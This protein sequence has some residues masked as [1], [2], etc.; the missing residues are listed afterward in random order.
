MINISWAIAAQASDVCSVGWIESNV[1]KFCASTRSVCSRWYF[2]GF[3]K[4]KSKITRIECYWQ[5][6]W[7]ICQNNVDEPETFG[8]LVVTTTKQV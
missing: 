7:I 3:D 4:R 2:P 5:P 1:G 8:F 6:A